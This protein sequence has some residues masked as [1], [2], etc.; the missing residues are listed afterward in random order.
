MRKPKNAIGKA[1]STALLACLL[2]L[3]SCRTRE[4]EPS[5]LLVNG[6]GSDYLI[7]LQSDHKQI[8]VDVMCDVSWSCIT[9]DETISSW[10][11]F[12]R[13]KYP[14][15]DNYWRFVMDVKALEEGT[16]PREAVFIFASG[17][18]RRRLI[19]RQS[20]PDP[21]RDV[22]IPGAYNVPGGDRIFDPVQD[23]WS[24]L[25]YGNRVSFRV[26]N[27]AEGRV[28]TV[29]GLPA[30]YQEGTVTT[31]EFRVMEKGITLAQGRFVNMAVIRHAEGLVWLRAD[32]GIY[33][34]LKEPKAS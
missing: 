23:Q 4:T 28:V 19:V 20:P 30:S 32:P 8:S 12:Y 6:R 10:I 34:I 21:M 24:L 3:G 1:V 11:S 33:F 31:I 2:L 14:E 13:E 25:H 16:E 18:L 7:I 22:T 15:R 26:I 5:F 29:S 9:E 17:N 27:P